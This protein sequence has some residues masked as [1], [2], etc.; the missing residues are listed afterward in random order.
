MGRQYKTYGYSSSL[1]SI[2]ITYATTATGCDKNFKAT[3]I[4]NLSGHEFII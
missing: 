4:W 2:P 1:P 3:R